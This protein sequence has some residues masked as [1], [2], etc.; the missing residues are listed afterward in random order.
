MEQKIKGIIRHIGDIGEKVSSMLGEK[1]PHAIEIDIILGDIR[2]LYEEVKALQTAALKSPAPPAEPASEPEDEKE[3]PA[4][5]DTQESGIGKQDVNTEEEMPAAE[6]GEKSPKHKTK[7]PA[8]E[9]GPAIL[10]DKYKAG[11]KLINESLAGNRDKENITS[12]IQSKPISSIGAALGIND[13]FQLIKDLFNGDKNSFE[14]TINT[15]DAASNFNE[16]FNYITSSF[17]W[18][19]EEDSVQLLLELVR[20]KFIVNQNE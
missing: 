20:R 8:R 14:N 5:S 9:S 10:A 1:S 18:D 4:D 6:T 2:A 13:R 16:A 3:A 12:K 15:L 17:D 11:L 7:R 19:M